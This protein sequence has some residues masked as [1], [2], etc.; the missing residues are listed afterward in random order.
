MLLHTQ[1]Q[2]CFE[3]QTNPLNSRGQVKKW[4]Q[5]THQKETNKQKIYAVTFLSA[6]GGQELILKESLS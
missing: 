5:K 3:K 6:L 4:D 1:L 2:V